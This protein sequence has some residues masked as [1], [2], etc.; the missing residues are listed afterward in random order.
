MDKVLGPHKEQDACVYIRVLRLAPLKEGQS[1]HILNGQ[2]YVPGLDYYV[3][4]RSGKGVGVS[5]DD[6][7][8]AARTISSR[9]VERAVENDTFMRLCDAEGLS[10]QRIITNEQAWY[11]VYDGKYNAPGGQQI[12][13]SPN[14]GE[15]LPARYTR[16]LRSAYFRYQHSRAQ[17][18]FHDK[19]P[20]FKDILEELKA[21][22]E[23]R[24]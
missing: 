20:R 1:Q 8:K 2:E 4:L 15:Y 18:K 22:V 12:P 23:G 3:P 13:P 7:M 21:D 9:R 11:V 14:W 19:Q 5:Y 17:R 10:F 6:S 24:S 16:T